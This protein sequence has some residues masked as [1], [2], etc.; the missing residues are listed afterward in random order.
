M[1]NAAIIVREKP[2][3]QVAICRRHC[4]YCP[5]GVLRYNTAFGGLTM[6]RKNLDQRWGE[7]RAIT[8]R[9]GRDD[10]LALAELVDAWGG[11]QSDVMRRALQEAVERVREVASS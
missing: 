7:S 11:T 10:R 6:P 8:V 1:G 5:H 9:L 3:C 2:D 4:L